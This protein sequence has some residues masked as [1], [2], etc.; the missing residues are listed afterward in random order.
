MS[1][2]V[3]RVLY[4]VFNMPVEK[5]DGDGGD[6]DGHLCQPD[7]PT[8]PEV[9]HELEPGHPPESKHPSKPVTV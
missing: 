4:V 6:D 1:L 2:L 9:E 7:H 5:F 8:D 3:L